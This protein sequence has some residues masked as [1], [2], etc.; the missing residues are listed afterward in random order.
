MGNQIMP[1]SPPK[2]PIIALLLSLFLLGGTGQ[3]FLGQTTKGIVLIAATIVTCG[4]AGILGA[5]D[6][7]M[8]A[9]RLQ[10]GNSVDEW[11]FFWTNNNKQLNS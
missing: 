3:I 5:I 7:Y 11:E 8:I 4:L 1:A 2:D 9:K 6:A 10:E